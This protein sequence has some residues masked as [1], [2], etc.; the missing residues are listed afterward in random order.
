MDEN[1]IDL[2]PELKAEALK[3]AANFKQGPIFTPHITRD[4]EGKIGTL[5]VPHV[6]GGA[7]WEGGA[8][9]AETG[10]VYIASTN[11]ESPYVLDKGD[12]E[13]TDM[14]YVGGR[15]RMTSAPVAPPRPAAPGERPRISQNVGPQGLPIVKP[16]WGRITA[17]DLN[18]GEHAWMKPNGDP[19]D[20][21]KNHPA[22]KG[23]DLS[24]I[25]NPDQA[26]LMVTKTLL[27]GG[28]GG[29]LF[30]AG[31]DGGSPIFRA[32]DKATGEVIHQMELP[33]GT[34]GIPMTYLANGR[35]F[36]VVAVGGRGIPAELI[37][38][39]VP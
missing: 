38:L 18:T 30:G 4:T 23:V 16:P 3:I 32:M 14:A 6:Q 20:Y 22:L 27:F 33:A 7:N 35:Q 8:L 15:P 11:R 29:G 39:A 31:T 24:G 34:T 36:V 26:T 13:R 12:P 25:G 21:V 2:T 5:I 9:D 17:I 1:L 19:P 10:I 37:A 28:V